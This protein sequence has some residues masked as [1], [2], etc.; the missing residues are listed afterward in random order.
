MA[1]NKEQIAERLNR[2]L[3]QR[4]HEPYRDGVSDGLHGYDREYQD[5]WDE[6]ERNDYDRGYREGVFSDERP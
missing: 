5:W 2:P 4:I 6:E 3:W 1:L